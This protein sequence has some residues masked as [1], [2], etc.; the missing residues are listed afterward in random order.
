MELN[1]E[2]EEKIVSE[3]LVDKF[4]GRST[5]RK[6]FNILSLVESHKYWSS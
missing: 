5:S 6:M 2:F 1:E 4:L 3:I